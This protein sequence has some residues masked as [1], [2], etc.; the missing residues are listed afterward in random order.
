MA[1]KDDDWIMETWRLRKEER[2]PEIRA[3]ERIAALYHDEVTVPALVPEGSDIS[4]IVNTFSL[5]IDGIGQRIASTMPIPY[6]SNPYT[7]PQSIDVARNRR[8]VVLSWW[9]YDTLDLKLG[10]MGRWWAAYA[11]DVLD[12]RPFKRKGRPE[13]VV[14]N[15]L[16]SWP[17]DCEGAECEDGIFMSIHSRSWLEQH[18]PDEAA[19]LK[20]GTDRR[21][22]PDPMAEIELVE[23]VSAEE[24]VY[25][26]QWRSTQ[27]E[28]LVGPKDF[29]RLPTSYHQN[30]EYCPVSSVGRPGLKRPQGQFNGMV[31]A[32][33]Q[34]QV[35]Q[36]LEVMGAKRRINPMLWFVAPNN[37]TVN[38]IQE[39]D[40]EENQYGIVSGGTL[41]VV[42]PQGGF[43][44]NNTIDR[45][46]RNQ[47]ASGR[48]PAEFAGESTSTVRTGRRGD[49]I[50]ASTVDFPVAEAQK[51][52]SRLLECANRA[53]IATDRYF[54]GGRTK[55]VTVN[56]G[57][58]R[59]RKVEY[60]PAKLWDPENADS[61]RV[62]YAHP[63]SDAN[64]LII[65]ILQR[66]GAGTM[67]TRT[68]MRVDPMIDDDEAEHDQIVAE[69]LEQAILQSVLAQA[70]QGTIPPND[71][72][73]IAELVQTN[74]MEL[75]AAIMKAQQEAQARQATPAPAS[76]PEAQ[77]GLA[78]PGMGA[79][80]PQAAPGE[81]PPALHAA[82]QNLSTL[83]MMNRVSPAEANQSPVR[84]P[85]E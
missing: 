65:S 58:A 56:W 39:A 30:L 50:M 40:P 81:L 33:Y 57:G 43:E 72:A 73:R 84:N 45:L 21:G 25:L 70:Q 59:D 85:V 48:I 61:H 17:G 12:V 79:E 78:Q 8:D 52:F 71:V 53:A 13:Y 16:L 2:E 3:G 44:A 1:Y 23:Y 68:A 28:M 11:S 69:A 64:S 7:S 47:R 54:F 10:L 76:A 32:Y 62:D 24:R 49:S 36:N 14:R 22:R 9:E 18:F 19:L 20:R 31:G 80:Q 75:P 46:E 77:P 60:D 74:R 51:H 66:K 26:A 82:F 83:R 55:K 34:Q 41:Q 29:I 67:S 27:N 5:G 38:V 15:P 35:L 6:F 63:G 4:T 42:A 37:E